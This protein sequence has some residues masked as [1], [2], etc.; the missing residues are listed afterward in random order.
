MNI[1]R[2]SKC[3]CWCHCQETCVYCECAGCEH[4][5]KQISDEKT[6]REPGKE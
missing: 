4:G 2:C 1:K 6:D 5:D 3:G